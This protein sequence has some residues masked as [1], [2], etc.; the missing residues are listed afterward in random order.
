MAARIE[1]LRPERDLL[2]ECPVWDERT[3]SLYWIDGRSQHVHRYAPASG[4]ADTWRA[5]AHIGSIAL[6]ES[7]RLLLALESDFHLLDTASGQISRIGDGVTHAADR[8]RL[9]DGRADRGGRFVVGSMTMGRHEP[10]G[11]LYQLDATGRVRT[12]DR[13]I[14]VANATC[15]SPDGRWLYFADTPTHQIRRYPYDPSTGACGPA[16]PFIDTRALGSP[17]DGAT[18]DAEGCLWVALVLAGKLVRFAPDGRVLRTV[19]FAPD[20]FITCPCFGGPALDVLYLTS[21]RDSG[22][23]LRS[24]NPDAG[25]V[26][27]VRDLGVQGLAEARYDDRQLGA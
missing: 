22:N 5:P 3:Q 15:F 19:D 20:A 8:M 13:G 17:P 26:F 4:T 12:L 14:Q 27:V 7:G 1:I 25:A 16:E 10:L 18:V 11:A 24:Q 6:C 21:I 23:L 2:G 9:N